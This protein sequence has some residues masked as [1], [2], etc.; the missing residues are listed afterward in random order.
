MARKFPSPK[1]TKGAPAPRAKFKALKSK[2]G[3]TPKLGKRFPVPKTGR[4]PRRG[5]MV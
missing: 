1:T 4:S 2:I 5:F 3:G